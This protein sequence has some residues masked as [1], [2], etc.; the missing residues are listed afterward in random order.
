MRRRALDFTG[1]KRK[2]ERGEERPKQI[3]QWWWSDLV[4]K[5]TE[6]ERKDPMATVWE[7]E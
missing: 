3:R 6:A 7:H 4:E 2:E 1:G 5:A